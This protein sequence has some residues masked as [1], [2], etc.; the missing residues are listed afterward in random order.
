M[1]HILQFL[2][3]VSSLP[4]AAQDRAKVVTLIGTS[5]PAIREVSSVLKNDK[6]IKDGPYQITRGEDIITSGFYKNGQK[7]SVWENY[8][9]KGVLISRKWYAGGARTGKWE[10]FNFDGKPDWDYDFKTGHANYQKQA[11]VDTG[12]IYYEDTGHVWVLGHV[13]KRPVALTCFAERSSFINRTLRYPNEAVN[14]EL[15]G[16]VKMATIV[17]ENGNPVDYEITQS[18]GTILDQE[19]L[20]VLKAFDGEFVPAEKD[21]KKVRSKFREMQVF[22]LENH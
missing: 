1:R 21:G 6:S 12:R 22:R 10:F 18:A 2:L 4:L 15:Q 11:P 8:T 14:N 17:D 13:D 9:S 5:R 3:F 20:R 16:T 7:D 19:A